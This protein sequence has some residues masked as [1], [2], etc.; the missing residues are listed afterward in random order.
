MKQRREKKRPERRNSYA[1]SVRAVNSEQATMDTM[2][3]PPGINPKKAL[4]SFT[5]RPGALLSPRR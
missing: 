3:N 5:R 2:A 4:E 1:G